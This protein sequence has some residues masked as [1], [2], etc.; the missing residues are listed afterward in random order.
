MQVFSVPM[1]LAESIH[2]VVRALAYTNN[3][4][5][6]ETK[7]DLE[8]IQNLF[9]LGDPVRLNQILMNLLSNSYKFTNAN[10]YAYFGFK[11][12]DCRDC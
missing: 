12:F 10:G 8:P 2:E 7:V 11:D 1:S 9:V 4:K 5:N 6:L 3:E